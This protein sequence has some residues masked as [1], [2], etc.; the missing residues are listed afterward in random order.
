MRRLVTGMEIES[1]GD[2]LELARGESVWRTLRWFSGQ[3]SSVLIPCWGLWIE[4]G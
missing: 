1:E 4:A 3:C 2:G